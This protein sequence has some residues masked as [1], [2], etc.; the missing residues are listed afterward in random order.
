MAPS[1]PPSPR[2]EL[3]RAKVNLALHV[4]GQRSDGYHLLESLVVFPQIGDRIA[5][6][7]SEKLELV[8]EGPFARDIEGPAEAN[9]IL[10]AVR[11]FAERAGLPCPDI[12]LT[13]T[14]R[15]PVSSGIGGGSSDAATTL[16][17][18][19]DFTGTYLPEEELH[20]LALSL[21]ADVPV[22][23]IPEPQIM[24]GIGDELAT[25][26]DLPACGI[27]L[28]N[29]KAGVSTPEV[30]RSMTRRDN[31]ALPLVP[32]SF[33]TLSQLT[34]YL[35]SCRNDMQDAAIQ[36]CGRIGDVLSVLKADSRIDL[37]RMSGSGAT[38]FGLC[39]PEHAP[40][41]ERSLRAD[42]PEWWIASGPL[43]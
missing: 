9:L 32:E 15:L 34:G 43:S 12:R 1:H 7:S 37:A 20:A 35:A 22:C 33:D 31:P 21:G 6:E 11:S 41:I 25:G 16:R 28:V 19:E 17:L 30:F 2:V 18:L 24:R 23:L 27:V 38:C 29:P 10:K 14:K 39:E 3:A 26:P 42:H 8:L 40:D 4:T 36:L 13:L 5:L